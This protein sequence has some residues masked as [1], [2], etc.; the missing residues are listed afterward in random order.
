M[1]TVLWKEVVVFII[2]G[3]SSVLFL[4]LA[5]PNYEDYMIRCSPVLVID[6]DQWN[7]PFHGK[8][9]MHT[10]KGKSL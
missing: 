7:L 4:D 6:I 10:S 1:N 9:E 2:S 8:A 5:G 3:I